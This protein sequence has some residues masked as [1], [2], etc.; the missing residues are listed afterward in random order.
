ML[1][2]KKKTLFLNFKLKQNKFKKKLWLRKHP[3]R[4]TWKFSDSMYFYFCF[5][6]PTPARGP[7]YANNYNNE[8]NLVYMIKK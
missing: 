1:I 5:G 7:L 4:M 8:K 3:K 6:A 2:W